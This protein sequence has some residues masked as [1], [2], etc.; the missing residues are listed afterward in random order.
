MEMQKGTSLKSKDG[1]ICKTGGNLQ[2]SRRRMNQSQLYFPTETSTLGT[3]EMSS[4]IKVG[5]GDI[6]TLKMAESTILLKDTSNMM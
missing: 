4:T 1:T 6:S 3:F 2:H 5:L